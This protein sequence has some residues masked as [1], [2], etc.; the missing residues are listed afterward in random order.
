VVS[1]MPEILLVCDIA[2]EYGHLITQ[3]EAAG[4]R[5]FRRRNLGA[6]LHSV[7][8]TLT[9]ELSV[10]ADMKVI[11]EGDRVLLG[12]LNSLHPKVQ[13][14]LFSGHEPQEDVSRLLQGLGNVRIFGMPLSDPTSDRF[15]SE[16]MS[17]SSIQGVAQPFDQQPAQTQ[18]AHVH[19]A[20]GDHARG[21]HGAGANHYTEEFLRRVGLSD[22]PVLL[23]G[24]TGVGKEVMARRL[25]TYSSRSGKPFFKL[26]CTALPSDLIESELFGYDKGAFTGATAD[27][28]GKFELAQNGTLLLDEIGDMDIRLQAKLLQVLQDGEVQPLG[29]ARVIKVNVRVMAATHRDLRSAITQGS[30]REDLYYRLSVINIVVH[31]LRER[32]DEILPLAEKL[33]LRHMAPG[34]TPPEIPESLKR[35]MLVHPWPG[36][37]RELENL[38]RRLIIYQDTNLLI[39]ELADSVAAA[40]RRRA[41]DRIAEV[42]RTPMNFNHFAEAS[43]SAESKLLI[44]TL[45]SS[46]WN[47]RQAAQQLNLDYKALL[48]K[49]QKYGIVHQKVRRREQDA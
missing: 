49:L 32:R 13:T 12:E 20:S 10:I 48:Y 3:L 31:P 30:F 23:H 45:E 19:A 9:H 46:R 8:S 43:R 6:A 15:V 26:N 5:V 14:V 33:L 42:P 1:V 34:S 16:L 21:G 28:P 35:A 11:G 18:T 39:E 17:S 4:A 38:M 37:V 29:S 36:N 22:V 2:E 27:K 47:R 25:W 41:T 7:R 24:E 40:R 44:E